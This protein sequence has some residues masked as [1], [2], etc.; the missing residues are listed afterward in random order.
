[1]FI[2]PAHTLAASLETPSLSVI[3]LLKFTLA[4]FHQVS[5]N[6]HLT[7]FILQFSEAAKDV[8]LLNAET[9]KVMK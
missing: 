7:N 4:T 8:L 1:M 6:S 3:S 2:L 9:T 5:Q